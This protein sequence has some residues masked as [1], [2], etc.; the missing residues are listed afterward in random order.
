MFH[1]RP[2]IVGIG[3]A[4]HLGSTTELA[5]RHAFAGADAEL[6]VFAGA[7][8]DLPLYAAQSPAQT[9]AVQRLLRALRRAD[10]VVIG[11]PGYHGGLSGVVKN[12]LD[13]IEF[14]RDDERPYLSGRAVG[15]IAN[16]AGW[17]GAMSALAATRNIV[18]ALRG[19]PTPLGVC[20]AGPQKPFDAQGRCTDTGVNRNLRA[21]A[22]EVLQ[23]AQWQR[24]SA[25]VMAPRPAKVA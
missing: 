6:D 16:A 13:Y 20:L 19:W 7:D 5:I 2:Y 23:F 22:A 3:G 15:C 21:L 14:M 1:P 9:P 10:G 11:S 8:L 18:H 12:A 17:Q 24:H 4:L 25:P